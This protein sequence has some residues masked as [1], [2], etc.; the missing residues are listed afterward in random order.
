MVAEEP[1]E[2]VGLVV[3]LSELQQADRLE[4]LEVGT[5]R[6]APIAMCFSKLGSSVVRTS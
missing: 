6:T 1:V 2:D 4:L 3:G 5:C